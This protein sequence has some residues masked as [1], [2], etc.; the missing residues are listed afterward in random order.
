[1]KFMYRRVPV[2]V[3]LLISATISLNAVPPDAVSGD[4]DATFHIV[5]YTIKGAMTFKVEGENLTGTVETQHTGRGTLTNGHLKDGK[6]TFTANFEKHESISFT[7]TIV[8]G[9]LTGEFQTEGNTGQ[10]TAEM[11]KAA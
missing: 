8:D 11:H 4:W 6:L 5:G 10:W 7:G 9:K 1:M 3:A 2:I